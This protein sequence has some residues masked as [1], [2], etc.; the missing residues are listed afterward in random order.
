VSQK[1]D[2]E[3]QLDTAIHIAPHEALLEPVGT[4]LEPRSPD[5]IV[6]PTV[7]PYLLRTATALAG[8][9]C[10]RFVVL[11]TMSAQA[12]QALKQCAAVRDLLVAVVPASIDD[13]LLPFRTS[14]L[15]EGVTR[16]TTN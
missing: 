3:A 2:G 11:C 13:N 9:L 12:E 8:T 16:P 1:L 4:G 5:T 7:R 6:M 15:P 10:C 14:G